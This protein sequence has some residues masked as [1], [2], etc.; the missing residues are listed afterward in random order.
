MHEAGQTASDS[1]IAV[2]SIIS[3]LMVF[4]PSSACSLVFILPHSFM[5]KSAKKIW[6]I[7]LYIEYLMSDG[8]SYDWVV[9]SHLPVFIL[10]HKPL[11]LHGDCTT[12]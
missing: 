2:L 3:Y 9:K 8:M 5:S 6:Y 4:S 10:T 11:G 1:F 12:K 7:W